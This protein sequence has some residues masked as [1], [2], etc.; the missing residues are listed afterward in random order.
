MIDERLKRYFQIVSHYNTQDQRGKINMLGGF[1]PAILMTEKDPF[2][3]NLVAKFHCVEGNKYVP[4]NQ[5]SGP[6]RLA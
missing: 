2:T 1:F 4:A 3:R 5:D 6:P